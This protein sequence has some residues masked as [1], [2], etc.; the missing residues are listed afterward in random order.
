[1]STSRDAL[2]DV[3]ARHQYDIE[4]DRCWSVEGPCGWQDG[5]AREHAEHQ[6]DALAAA[7][8]RTFRVD[9]VDAS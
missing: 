1:M 7:G 2:I 4:Y 3:L 8:I 5:G 6:A 9:H